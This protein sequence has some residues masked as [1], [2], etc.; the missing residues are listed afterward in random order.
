MTM[1]VV[2]RLRSGLRRLLTA[3]AGVIALGSVLAGCAVPKIDIAGP[4]TARPVDPV[5]MSAARRPTG[6]IYA[7]APGYRPLFEDVRA[8]DVG[9]T[10]VVR[11]EERINS[12]Q[13][14]NTSVQRTG[15]SRAS[16]PSLAKLPGG[17]LLRGLGIEAD[18][19]NKFNAKGATGASNILSG[20]VAVT[21]TEVLPNGNLM[22]AGEKQIGTN[23]E[24]ER[25][26][27]SGVV[28]PTNIVGG[29]TVS[30]TQVADARIEYRGQGAIDDA[31]T[32]G[33]LSRFFFSVLPF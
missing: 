28:N 6:G 20:T 7:S 19:D 24:T 18:S 8:R 22:V 32:V 15:S 10:L 33:W 29:N 1:V 25:V 26:R 17:G 5:A 4:T 14:N 11:L 9:D 2:S 21:V 27:F 23:R 16:I 12:T 13:S 31:Q 3:A 30:S